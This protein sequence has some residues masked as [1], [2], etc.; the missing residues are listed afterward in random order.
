MCVFFGIILQLESFEVVL[1][2]CMYVTYSSLCRTYE[3]DRKSCRHEYIC[4]YVHVCIYWKGVRH[5]SAY[6]KTSKK[7]VCMYLK[8][9]TKTNHFARNLFNR[10][11]VSRCHLFLCIFSTIH[12]F[13]LLMSLYVSIRLCSQWKDIVIINNKCAADRWRLSI[14][15][16]QAANVILSCS[17]GF[18]RL[19]GLLFRKSFVCFM[20]HLFI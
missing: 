16:C 7:N 11:A 4:I 3:S 15:P 20:K 19:K 12:Y 13:T 1:Y 17:C 5:F 2:V 9:K 6:S 14:I 10:T 8:M 18:K